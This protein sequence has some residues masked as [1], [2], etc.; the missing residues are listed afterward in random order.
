M[1]RMLLGFLTAGALLTM[2]RVHRTTQKGNFLP[3]DELLKVANCRKFL[4]AMSGDPQE[5][6]NGW[7]V[8]NAAPIS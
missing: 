4:Q 1:E 7:W 6:R 2:D 8:G 5:S 3:G